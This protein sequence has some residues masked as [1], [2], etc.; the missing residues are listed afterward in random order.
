[1]C[2][3]EQHMR[4]VFYIVHA[5]PE[6]A[7]QVG[8]GSVLKKTKLANIPDLPSSWYSRSQLEFVLCTTFGPA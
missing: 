3:Q 1:M 2:S 7:E 6:D 8:T 5:Q 4:L